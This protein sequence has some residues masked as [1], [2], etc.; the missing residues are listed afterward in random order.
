MVLKPDFIGF[1]LYPESKRY[2]GN[3]YILETEIPCKIK[4]TGV[5]VNALLQDVVQWVNRLKLDYVQLHGNEPA[6]YCKELNEMKIPVIKTFGMDD[7]FDFNTM[8][9]YDNYCDFFL[10]DTKSPEH[11]GSGIKF[12]W[13]L[14]SSYTLSKPFILSGGIS[15]DDLVTVL[16]LSEKIPLYAID[17]NSRFETAPGIKNIKMIREF[18]GS[19]RKHTLHKSEKK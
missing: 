9:A 1:I 14:L 16:S 18:I 19:V 12:N 13:N 4:R 8:R 15:P 7:F 3:D 11:G 17:I 10:F 6:E 2:V 5:F